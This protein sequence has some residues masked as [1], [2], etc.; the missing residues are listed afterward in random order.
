MSSLTLENRSGQRTGDAEA[1]PVSAALLARSEPGRI[2][3]EKM[4]D[5]TVGPTVFHLLPFCEFFK[6]IT[7]L[8]PNESSIKELKSWLD[9]DLDA[10]DWSH[11]STFMTQLESNREAWHEKEEKLRTLI[12]RI[13][14]FDFSKENP[15]DPIVLPKADCLLS[16]WGLDVSSKDK[17]SFAR[18]LIKLSSLLKLGGHLIYVGALNLSYYHVGEHKFHGCTYD[19]AF[20]KK[21]LE[22][23]GYS[24]E[25]FEIIERKVK[26][27]SVDFEHIVVVTALKKREIKN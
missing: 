19:E 13:V 1:K 8:E 9:K 6:E 10:Y 21:V 22:D 20:L 5:I 11:A 7:V 17:D 18:N 27:V 23:T 15:T 14:K 3:G 2:K 25:S 26:R 12:K 16:A 24:I 4:I